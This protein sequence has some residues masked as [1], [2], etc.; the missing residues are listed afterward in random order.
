MICVLA[1]TYMV[2]FECAL[3]I[4]FATMALHQAFNLSF[5]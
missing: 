1:C 2:R 5:F 3:K 4:C